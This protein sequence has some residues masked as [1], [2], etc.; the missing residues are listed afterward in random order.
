[1]RIHILPLFFM[2]REMA[3]R[4]A[5]ICRCVIQAGS[6][7][8][9]PYS[10]KASVEPRQALPFM[11]PRCCLRYLTFFGIN[12]VHYPRRVHTSGPGLR[13]AWGGSEEQDPPTTTPSPAPV[14]V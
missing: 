4:A 7:D 2:K 8:L 5:S 10:P 12:I 14:A 9:S 1:M 11:R 6:S 3:T 13:C